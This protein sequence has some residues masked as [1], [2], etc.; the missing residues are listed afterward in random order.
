MVDIKIKV[1]LQDSVEDI[2]DNV[3]SN[4]FNNISSKNIND[5]FKN[6]GE[7]LLSFAKGYLKFDNNGKLVNYDN[8]IGKPLLENSYNGFCFG[9]TND[10][11][12]YSCK[13]TLNGANIDSIIIYGD[14]TAKQFPIE[15][16]KD[17]DIDNKIY[18][19]DY[20][21]AIKFA[22]PSESHSIT[23]TKWNRANYNACITYIAV[24]KNDFYINSNAITNIESKSQITGQAEDIYYGV[25]PNSGNFEILDKDGEILEYIEEGIL[26]NSNLPYDIYLK[27]KQI[28]S[29]LTQDSEYNKNNKLLSVE[30]TNS[31]AKFENIPFTGLQLQQENN[32]YFIL[33]EVLS[34]LYST[35][36]I[37]NMLDEIIVVGNSVVGYSETSIKNYLE[38]IIIPFPYLEKG[39][40]KDTINKI[41]NL[42][43]LNVIENNKGEIKFVSA[44]PVKPKQ[45]NVICIPAKSQ[46][47]KLEET[48][49]KKNKIN[50]VGY[51][52]RNEQIITKELFKLPISFYIMPE[53]TSVPQT[54]V[55][56]EETLKKYNPNIIISNIETYIASELTQKLKADVKYF[57]DFVNIMKGSTRIIYNNDTYCKIVTSSLI[58]TFTGSKGDMPI[59]EGFTIKEQKL[60]DIEFAVDALYYMGIIVA[61]VHYVQYFIS[62]IGETISTNEQTVNENAD[63]IIESNEIMQNGA[64]YNN[65]SMITDIITNN[66]LEDY[67]K[68]IATATITVDCTNYYDEKGKL[69]K[70]WDNGDII[71]V[72]DILRIDKDNNGTPQSVYFNGEAKLWQVVGRNFRKKGK[73]FIDLELREIKKY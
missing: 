67:G 68:G 8:S 30:A 70:N 29:H 53:D 20:E 56:D 48:I 11:G 10:Y 3:Q 7:N 16:Y 72:G 58:E 33:C 38:N 49:I 39:K 22:E 63:F 50:S 23:F 24:L 2:I 13:I 41:C 21:W 27:N 73:P 66:L 35:L 36:K 19:D 59:T 9:A 43:Q 44:R 57:Y 17:E 62:I 45:K 55:N 4:E 65:K 46:F 6:D 18:S 51:V 47:G 61:N 1:Q 14:K 60:S 71:D 42:A 32:L 52:N 12:E 31:I 64:K 69:I 54:I 26:P 15:A 25:V 37:D 28:Q 5:I 40:I 34:P